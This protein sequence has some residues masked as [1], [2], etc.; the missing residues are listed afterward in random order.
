MCVCVWGGGGGTTPYFYFLWHMFNWFQDEE[1]CD[2]RFLSSVSLAGLSQNHLN[3]CL[4][5][6]KIYF[7]LNFQRNE[8]QRTL[9]QRDLQF[10]K[11]IIPK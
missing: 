1:F 7:N 4:C 3:S 10:P 6:M 8:K 5:L 11:S 9:L 2:L